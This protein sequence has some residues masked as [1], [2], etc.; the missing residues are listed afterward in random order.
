MDGDC[1]DIGALVA[2][3]QDH[4]AFLVVD[5]AH[6]TGVLGDGGRGL[7]AGQDVDLVVGTCGKA[8]GSFGAFVCCSNLVREFLINFCGGFIYSTALPPQVV[9]AVDA[10]LDLLPGLEAERG[11]LAAHADH[12]RAELTRLGFDPGESTTQIVPLIVGAEDAAVRLAAWLEERGILAVAIRPPTV[13]SG[14]ARLRI[15]LS[16]LHDENHLGRLVRALEDWRGQG[17]G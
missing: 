7:V 6:A 17:H 1:S 14:Q 10:A 12:L 16:A 4:N 3:A 11:R 5:E 9:G 2:L 15:A 8:L 13:E